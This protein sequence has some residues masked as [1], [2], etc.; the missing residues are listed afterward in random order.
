MGCDSPPRAEDAVVLVFPVDACTVPLEVDF[1]K[2]VRVRV[3]VTVTVA[4]SV[5][6]RVRVRVRVRPLEFGL[7]CER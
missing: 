4:V 5:R 1:R 3:R 6:F 2:R 7:Q